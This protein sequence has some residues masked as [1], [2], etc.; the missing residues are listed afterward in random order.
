MRLKSYAKCSLGI[1]NYVNMYIAF[2]LKNDV[3]FILLITIKY[4]VMVLL[5]CLLAV[6]NYFLCLLHN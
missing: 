4:P 2:M 6:L 5:H 1:S 3:G